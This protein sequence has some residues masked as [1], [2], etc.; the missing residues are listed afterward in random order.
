MTIENSVGALTNREVLNRD[1][2]S[3]QVLINP[4]CRRTENQIT[5]E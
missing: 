1:L 4:N 2:Q 3:N 5:N